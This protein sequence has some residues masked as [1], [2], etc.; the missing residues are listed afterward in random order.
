VSNPDNLKPWPKGVSGNPGGQYKLPAELKAIKALTHREVNR[1]ISRYARMNQAEIESSIQDE[2]LPILD[3]AICSVF[4]KSVKFGDF[5]RL[6]F[7]LD[8]CVGKA[9]EIVPEDDD[10]EELQKL[11]MNELLMLVKTNLPEAG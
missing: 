10:R 8:R 5:T 4:Q 1:L 9:K 2:N 6:S 11:T 7:L 3:V